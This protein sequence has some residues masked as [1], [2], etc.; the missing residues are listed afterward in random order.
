M[1]TSHAASP[2]TASVNIDGVQHPAT[3]RRY[4]ET[5]EGEV[6]DVQAVMCGG[7]DGTDLVHLGDS[8]LTA[9]SARAL[10]AHLVDVLSGMSAPEDT[11]RA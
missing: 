2:Y 3:E 6:L 11:L 10:A 8:A 9:T 5:A 1:T 7:D 4:F